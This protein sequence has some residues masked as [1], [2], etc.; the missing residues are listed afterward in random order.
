ML[1]RQFRDQP[2]MSVLAAFAIGLLI[3]RLASTRRD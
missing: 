1:N 2:A 3:S